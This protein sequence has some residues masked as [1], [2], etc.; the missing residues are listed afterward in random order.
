MFCWSSRISC[1]QPC[2][3]VRSSLG[4][5]ALAAPA[6]AS[7]ASNVLGHLLGRACNHSRKQK[8]DGASLLLDASLPPTAAQ[9][10]S[11]RKLECAQ[12]DQGECRATKPRTQRK[13]HGN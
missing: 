3:W 8:Q 13:I 10:L 1:S 5:I 4:S 6:S 7:L 2:W 11:K 9:P 12:V